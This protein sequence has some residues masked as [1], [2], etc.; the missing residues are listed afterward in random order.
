[1]P[2]VVVQVE[3]LQVDFPLRGGRFLRVLNGIDLNVERGSFVAILGPSGSG[4]TTLLRSIAGLITPR[5]GEVKLLASENGGVRTL[6]LLS[7]N[8]QRPVLLPWLN[9]RE[10]ALLP[11]RIGG[12]PISE[13]VEERLNELLA[14]VGLFGFRTALPHELSGGMQMRAALVRSFMTTPK[15]VLMDEPFAALDEVT[16][17]RL[18]LE[19]LQLW[20]RDRCTIL[21]VTHNIQE[22]VYLA[23]RVVVLSHRPARIIEDITVPLARPR[24]P[25]MRESRAYF[26]LINSLY[27][28]MGHD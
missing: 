7:M 1:M 3:S 22:A 23:D 10:N 28:C 5:S 9:V 13:E 4:K 20:S 27:G 6:P 15:I 2:D 24:M 18:G 25:A 12:L 21:F 14:M 17:H 26:D 8:F 11:Y 16:R 19:L